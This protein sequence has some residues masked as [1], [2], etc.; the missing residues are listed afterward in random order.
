MMMETQ[1]LQFILA[2]QGAVDTDYLLCNLGS[3]DST[4]VSELICNNEKFALCCPF[5]QPKVVAI[6]RL[7]LCRAKDCQG[8]CNGLHLCK[9]YFLCGTCRFSST[10]RGCNFS[11]CLDSFHNK[12]VLTEHGLEDLSRTELCLLLL[13]SD[14]NFLPPICYDYNNGDGEFGRCK[15]GFDCKRL[16]IC[17]KYMNRDCSC[18]RNHDFSAPQ[19]LRNLQ[20]RDVPDSLMGSLKSIYANKQALKYLE[21]GQRGN[22]QPR[23]GRRG[24]GSR[25]LSEETKRVPSLLDLP[26][27]FEASNSNLP[28][29]GERP[30]PVKDKTEICMY[31]IKGHCKWGDEKC[32]KVHNK[33]PYRWEIKRGGQWAAM[34]DNETIERDF[35]DPENIYSTTSPPVN[36]DI[37]SCG[38]NNV[39][40]I[41]TTNSV[42]EPE[43]ILTTEWLWFWE[44]ER[45]KWNV[46][47]SADGGH[48]PADMHSSTLEQKF[49][50][51][52][53]DV[54][55]FIAGSQSYSLSFADMIQTNKRYGTKR[56]VRRRPRFVSAAEVQI[57]R[58]QK[59]TSAPGQFAVPDHWDKTQIPQTGFKRI[60]LQCS[61][62]EY[63]E[64]ELLFSQTM[65]GFDIVRLERIQ[66]KILWESFQLKKTQMKN[67]NNGRDVTEKKLFH[68]T[69]NEFVDTICHTNFDWRICGTHGTV[70]GKGSYF[71]RDAKYSNS[72]TSDS[73]VRSMFVARVLVGDYTTGSSSYVRPPSKDGGNIN[74]FDSCVDRVHDPSIYVV[75]ET[76]QIYPEYLLQYRAKHPLD[77]PTGFV[78]APIL[79]PT[80]APKPVV[81]PTPVV[82]PKRVVAPQP[83]AP[84]P[85][86]PVAPQPPQPVAPQPPQ[87]V[88]PQPVTPRSPFQYSSFDGT[89]RYQP[90][91]SSY[92]YPPM[93]S[94]TAK[95]KKNDSCVIA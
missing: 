81:T 19:P 3:G 88:A 76:H 39:R 35:C 9:I 59:R 54:V 95:P 70:Y 75:F 51:N 86:Q 20:K 21:S 40:R 69:G 24:N 15:E 27:V 48:S 2:N 13:Q 93:P 87:P 62:Q 23:G 8:S 1:I 43:F 72:Y 53:K 25:N 38:G 10:R 57:K 67:N 11:H 61:S 82:A 71:A 94:S 55:E 68:G 79:Q 26:G 31:F 33:M 66:N 46:Y 47:A 60:S 91:T 80:P 92:R 16:H 6:T 90:S 37:M 34:P 32:F 28:S 29:K 63:K 44:D 42:K 4:N 18:F 12:M 22:R 50:E 56:V 7:K 45:G 89:L 5:G 83:V 64:I 17:E 41:S 85:P 30:K 78:P 14:D 52:D 77:S 74:L 36:F 84:Q 65:R 49:L 73:N 58:S